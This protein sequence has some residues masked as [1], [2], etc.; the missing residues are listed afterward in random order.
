LVAGIVKRKTLRR[1][2]P[3][4]LCGGG[5]GEKKKKGFLTK[6]SVVGTYLVDFPV[7]TRGQQKKIRTRGVGP[8]SAAGWGGKRETF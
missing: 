6:S 5:G 8:Q 3:S 2:L 4:L 7:E 1:V